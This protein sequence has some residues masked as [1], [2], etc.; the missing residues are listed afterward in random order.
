MRDAIV[1][2]S[3][4]WRQAQAEGLSVVGMYRKMVADKQVDA[5]HIHA[6]CRRLSSYFIDATRLYEAKLI[7]RKVLLLAISHPGLNTFY[8]VAVPL[9]EHKAGGHN[10]VWAAQVLK[11]VLPRHGSGMY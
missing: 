7:S 6:Q 10:S 8:E 11:D 4:L 5:N 9:N 1:E 2:L 3:A